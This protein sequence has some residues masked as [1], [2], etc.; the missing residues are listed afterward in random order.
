MSHVTLLIKLVAVAPG[1]YPIQP[2]TLE[3][4]IKQKCC[5]DTKN[6]YL[7]DKAFD[8]LTKTVSEEELTGFDNYMKVGR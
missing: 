5:I 3:Q 6:V 8:I 7:R 4:R 1:W 2:A